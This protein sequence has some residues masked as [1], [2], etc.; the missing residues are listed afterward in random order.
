MNTPFQID[1]WKRNQNKIQVQGC[2]REA[3]QKKLRLSKLQL[4]ELGVAPF[5]VHPLKSTL[6]D[7]RGK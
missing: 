7:E 6:R 2:Y 4:R 3:A 1:M 5:E